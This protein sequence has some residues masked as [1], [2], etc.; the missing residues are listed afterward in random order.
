ME[1]THIIE[2]LL[3]K[4]KMSKCCSR[5]VCAGIFINNNFLTYTNKNLDP[6]KDS[7]EYTL[8]KCLECGNERKAFYNCCDKPMLPIDKTFNSVIHAEEDL[9]AHNNITKIG[10]RTIYITD[11]PCIRCS[12]L[13][14]SFGIKKIY[15]IRDFNDNE[16][17]KLL[18][19]NGTIL[20][21]LDT[22]NIRNEFK[23]LI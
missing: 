9:I 19:D 22:S 17:K 18:E 21:K 20:I 12:R 15:Y 6:N 1:L 7:C 4:S 3:A 23:K 8:Y 13:L 14:V 5:K 16:G 2:T 10:E 11:F